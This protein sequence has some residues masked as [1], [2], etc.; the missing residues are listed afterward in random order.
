MRKFLQNKLWRDKAPEL[1]ER[2]GSRI[3]LKSLSD[4][5]FD[6]QLRIKFLEEAHEVCSSASKKNLIEEL[7]DVYEVIDALRSLHG[8]SQAELRFAK[9]KKCTERGGFEQRKF[10]TIAEHPTQSYG[11]KYCLAQPKKYP[12]ITDRSESK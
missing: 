9:G 1:M 4:Q 10:V 5:E 8:I 12:E 2:M 7:A 3:H 11:E 6:E